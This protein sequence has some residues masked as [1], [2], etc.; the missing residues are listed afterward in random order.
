MA[1]RTGRVWT[2][3]GGLHF[4]LAAT[5]ERQWLVDHTDR[6]GQTWT[7]VRTELGGV[8]GNMARHL[9]DVGQPGALIAVVGDDDIGQLLLGRARMDLPGVEVHP[10][11]VPGA[12][13]GVVALLHTVGRGDRKRLVVGPDRSAV[14]VVEYQHVDAI[15]HALRRQSA[16][17]ILDGYVLRCRVA[18]WVDALQRFRA[19]GWRTHLELVP[20][21]LGHEVRAAALAAVVASCATLSTNMSTIERVLDLPPLSAS[22][23]PSDRAARLADK[24][25]RI[26]SGSGARILARFGRGDAQLCLRLSEGS[27]PELWSY[28]LDRARCGKS[29]QDRLLVH[30]LTGAVELVGGRRLPL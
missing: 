26:L 17:L 7:D 2:V 8:G 14:D 5:I 6:D 13:S 22:A 27:E 24:A 15:L 19:D 28:D 16:E 25:G 11:V 12:H 10:V 23:L 4:D 20:H 18:G 9:H 29:T 1:N 3:L 21:D 30:E